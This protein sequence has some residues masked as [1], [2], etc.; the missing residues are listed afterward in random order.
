MAS[1][2]FTRNPSV[3]VLVETQVNSLVN[4][5]GTLVIIGRKAAS[6]GSVAVGTPISID[7]FG[8]PVAAAAEAI[9]KFGA[10][11]EVGEMIVAA[12]SGVLYSDLALKAFPTIVVIPMISTAV[13]SDL[14][15]FLATQLTVP[16]PYLVIPFPATDSVALA[17]IKAHA[18]AISSSD[19]GD[20]AQFGTFAFLATDV[21]TSSATP[22]GLAAAVEN[23][24][25]P[26]LRD[27]AVTKANGI[28]KV[29]SAYAAVCASLGLPFLPLNSVKVGGLIA[30][31]QAAD[32]HT[33]GDTGTV[34]LG[35]DAGLAPLMVTLDGG[36]KISRSITTRQVVT[37]IVD[38]A[39]FDMQDFQVLYYLRKNSYN[40][41][42]QPRY[43]R[44]KATVVKLL[45]LKSELIGICKVLE[46]LEMLQHVDL[47]A[48]QFT[49][50][51]LPNNRHAAVYAVPV[52]VVPGFH[53]KGIDLI[54][55]TQFDLVIG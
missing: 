36:V 43:K 53:N 8:D 17:A 2:S 27:L 55:T 18:I 32:W 35:L 19:R 47:F 3:K 12:I 41:A 33:A 49:V 29:A 50:A 51:R 23:I 5:D 44:A 40:L 20:N 34:A 26:W 15:A 24:C 6:G 39:Y 30:P 52:N 9:V 22:A 1:F 13:S 11:S 37:G 14:A 31:S 28:H 25:I 46:G 54:G 42:Q 16:M 21:A 7:N 4:A 48:N 45:S 38:T 10:G